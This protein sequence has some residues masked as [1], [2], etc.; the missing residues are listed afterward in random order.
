LALWRGL[1]LRVSAA[2]NVAEVQKVEKGPARV[3][4]GP[5]E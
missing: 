3:H 5:P 2:G 1:Q 4:P